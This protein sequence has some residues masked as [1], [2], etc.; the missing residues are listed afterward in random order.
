MD[1]PLKVTP[2]FLIAKLEPLSPQ[3]IFMSP[4]IHFTNLSPIPKRILS[5]KSTQAN[6]FK[7]ESFI[8]RAMGQ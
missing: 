1:K 5:I 6:I 2:K 3:N 7:K 4:F 8:I